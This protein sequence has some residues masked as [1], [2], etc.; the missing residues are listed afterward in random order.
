[1]NYKLLFLIPL[2][3]LVACSSTV[4]VCF[5]GTERERSR[6]CPTL[7]TTPLTR[8]EAERAAD[9]F[10]NA[11]VRARSLQVSRVNTFY[12][13]SGNFYTELLF[14]IQGNN[15]VNRVTLEI[16]GRTGSVSCYEGCAF[17]E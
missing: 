15:T 14:S 6:D 8:M 4:Y 13:A 5:D 10:A 17:L 1:M 11:Y 2:I 16:N 12:N 9:N 7:P 3:F